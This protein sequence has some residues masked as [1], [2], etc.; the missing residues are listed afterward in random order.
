MNDNDLGPLFATPQIHT[1]TDGRH[2]D[3]QGREYRA[4]E[5][6]GEITFEWVDEWVE[7]D[8]AQP[9]SPALGRYIGRS[10]VAKWADERLGI[11]L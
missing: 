7:W 1:D 4:V 10:I 8:Y 5:V 9:M 6:D 11:D 2:W 3:G